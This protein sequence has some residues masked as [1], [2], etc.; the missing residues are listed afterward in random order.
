[1]GELYKEKG[2]QLYSEDFV[3]EDNTGLEN[4]ILKNNWWPQRHG[5]TETILCTSSIVPGLE[6]VWW[7]LTKQTKISAVRGSPIYS[8]GKVSRLQV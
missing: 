4:K 7:I 6:Q 3:A 2:Q 1:M 8:D 5:H